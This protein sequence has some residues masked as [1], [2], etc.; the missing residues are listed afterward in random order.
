MT[1]QTPRIILFNGPPE[2]GKDTLALELAQG[3]NMPVALAK[4]SFPLKRAAAS[5]YDVDLDEFNQMSKNQSSEKLLGQTPRQV[6]I[7]LSEDYMKPKHGDA[8]FGRIMVSTVNNL[9]EECTQNSIDV[10]YV[11]VSDCGFYEE[12]RPLVDA[13]GPESFLLLRLHRKGK[14]FGSDSRSY[15][16]PSDLGILS[17]DYYVPECYENSASW[18]NKV[19]QQLLEYVRQAFGGFQ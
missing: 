8:V 15:V 10:G 19:R 17:F 13:F 5:L 14:D 2:S 7:S 1:Q 18:Q 6:Q 9:I 11:A 12:L 3:L 16:D 4:M